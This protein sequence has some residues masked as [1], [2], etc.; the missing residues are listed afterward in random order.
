MA[1]KLITQLGL[2]VASSKLV[3]KSNASALDHHQKTAHLVYAGLPMVST[4]LLDVLH[5][6]AQRDVVKQVSKIAHTSML[7]PVYGAS[8]AVAVGKGV[9]LMKVAL[10]VGGMSTACLAG[11]AIGWWLW[12]RKQR[13][14][15]NF[16]WGK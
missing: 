5:K 13:G 6:R 11:V 8:K 10:V 1:L 15:N 9:A 16:L 7:L 4:V 14:K 12:G 3:P 2:H